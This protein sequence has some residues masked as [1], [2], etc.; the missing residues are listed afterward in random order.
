M[1][2]L[3]IIVFI[4]AIALIAWACG[5]LKRKKVSASTRGMT[6]QEYL[7]N[8]KTPPEAKVEDEKFMKAVKGALDK[9]QKPLGAKEIQQRISELQK[10][11]IT[12]YGYIPCGVGSLAQDDKKEEPKDPQ[13]IT[14]ADINT[15]VEVSSPRIYEGTWQR[16][17]LVKINAGPGDY[18]YKTKHPS[19]SNKPEYWANARKTKEQ[20]PTPKCPSCRGNSMHFGCDLCHGSGYLPVGQQAI[21]EKF[22]GHTIEVKQQHNTKWVRRELVEIQLDSLLPFVC[23]PKEGQGAHQTIRWGEAR[24]L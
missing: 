7:D 18:Q 1:I 14:E 11:L 12:D 17:Q 9:P 16:R 8:C 13:E 15:W 2:I 20:K 3:K 21:D 10:K 23:K 24:P 19:Y 6:F 5:L 4:V 22:I